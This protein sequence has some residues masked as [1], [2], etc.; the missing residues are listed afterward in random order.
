MGL[1]GTEL[2]P[3]RQ[4]RL[5]HTPVGQVCWRDALVAIGLGLA[6]TIIQLVYFND[7][8]IVVR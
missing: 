4:D 7:P 6:I 1:T 5:S 3:A 8:T 2:Q